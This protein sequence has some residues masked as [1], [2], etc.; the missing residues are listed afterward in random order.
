MCVL[1]LVVSGNRCMLFSVILLIFDLKGMAIKHP[2]VFSINT[3][4]LV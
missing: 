4:N 2:L 1:F 3:C